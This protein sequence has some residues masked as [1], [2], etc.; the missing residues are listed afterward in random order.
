MNPASYEAFMQPRSVAIVGASDDGQKTGGRT[1]RYLD[2]YGYDGDVYPINP[3]RPTVQGK[4]AHPDLAALGRP[5]DLAVIVTPAEYSVAALESCVAA[6]VPAVIMISSGF[7]ELNAE[8]ARRQRELEAVL[9]GSS[10]RVLGPNC[11][12]LVNPHQVDLDGDGIGNECDDDLDGDGAADNAD[13]CLTLPNADQA[14]AD[15]DG[16]GDVCDGDRDGDGVAGADNCPTLANPDQADTDADRVGNACDVD[17]D[18]D[19]TADIA[20]RCPLLGTPGASG[21]PSVDRTLK[22]GLK[23]SKRLLAGQLSAGAAACQAGQPVTVWEARRGKDR[24][25]D[26]AR[27]NAAGRFKTKLGRRTGKFYARVSSSVAD[28]VGACSAAK[29]RKVTVRRR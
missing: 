27:S 11:V 24:R 18:A 22:L 1:L 12:G 26:R 8:G 10:T 14:D 15:G 19:G 16:S 28:G 29:S 5:V 13:N 25:I 4:Q 21:C 2:K 6:E 3:R 9:R 7:A 20:D 17:D 23:I